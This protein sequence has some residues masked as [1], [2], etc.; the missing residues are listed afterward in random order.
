VE[1]YVIHQD[2]SVDDT[3]EEFNWQSQY[4]VKTAEGGV[5]NHPSRNN[6]GPIVVP[7]NRYFVLGDNRDNSAD[8]RYWGFVPDSLVRGRPIFVYYSYQMDTTRAFAWLT[9]IRWGR[10][11]ERID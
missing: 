7:P 6:W 4:L 8:S 2:S 5:I 3:R 9:R 11:G 1:S 10:I